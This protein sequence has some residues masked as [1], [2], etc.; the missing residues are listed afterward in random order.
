M[1][2]GL[3]GFKHIVAASDAPRQWRSFAWYLCSGTNDAEQIQL[4]IDDAVAAGG[5]TVILSP[6]TFSISSPINLN[7]DLVIRGQG[8]AN[9]NLQ[10][11]ANANVDLFV[12]NRAG[13][14]FECNLEY[15]TLNGNKANNTSGNGIN[16][17]VGAG[18]L[19]DIHLVYVFVQ[20][21]SERGILLDNAWG[22]TMEGCIVEFC[23]G[24]GVE[25]LGGNGKINACKIG[26]NEGQ[27]NLWIRGNEI[28]VQG[29][30]CW[31]NNGTGEVAEGI[32]VSGNRNVIM[33]CDVYNSDTEPL[34]LV[35]GD[36]NSVVGNM[37][38]IGTEAGSAEGVQLHADSNRNLVESN[39]FI[40]TFDNKAV[41][42]NGTGNIVRNNTGWITE[43][44]GT[45]SVTSGA[46]TDVITHGLSVTPTA[47]DIRITFTEQG[48]NDYGR[49]WVDSITSTQFTLNVSAD[50]GGNNLD[51]SWQAIVL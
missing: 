20:S 12:Y 17:G 36:D 46:T 7:G 48:S 4:A 9:T 33:G 31:S 2:S 28:M 44:S 41:D 19:Q 8:I 39:Q 1:S 37:L 43:A 50:P 23:E 25:V 3:A 26:R 49:W 22:L 42:D 40:G 13:N 11:A 10:L 45:G 29:V 47:A 34:I 51:F 32:R 30:Q 21:F 18:T 16:T 38:Y 14:E 15:M 27:S 5:G 6:G 35:A 24:T